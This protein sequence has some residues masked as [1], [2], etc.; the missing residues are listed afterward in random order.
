MG[1]KKKNC[2][3]MVRDYWGMEEDS[4]GSQ[5]PQRNVALEKKNNLLTST[6]TFYVPA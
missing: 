1:I 3:A 6:H 2:Q 4:S 5:G